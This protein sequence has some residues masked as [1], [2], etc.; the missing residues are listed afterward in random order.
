MSE[1][2]SYCPGGN[3]WKPLERWL[4]PAVCRRQFDWMW[5]EAGMECYRCRETGGLLLLDEFGQC[6]EPTEFGALTADFKVEYQRSTGASYCQNG[7]GGETD[8][9]SDLDESFGDEEVDDGDDDDEPNRGP[10]T[11]SLI[12]L[13]KDW[14]VD[15]SIDPAEIETLVGEIR[16][17]N[18]VFLSEL[19]MKCA[20]LL[21][22]AKYWLE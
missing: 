22:T 19:E 10:N 8:R 1:A 17:F 16:I 7:N 2:R 15:S 13:V 18:D 5:S 9:A 3:N 21:N 6:F 12:S 14:G 11:E 20:S 4:P